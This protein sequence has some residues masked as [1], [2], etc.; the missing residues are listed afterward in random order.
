MNSYYSVSLCVN[1][2][3]AYLSAE[4]TGGDV[5]TWPP[6]EYSTVGRLPLDER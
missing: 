5:F 4:I 2:C 1:A 3:V 6:A